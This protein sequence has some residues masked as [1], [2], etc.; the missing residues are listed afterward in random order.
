MKK[1]ISNRKKVIESLLSLFFPDYQF[2]TLIK[3]K[4]YK[5]ESIIN[6][7]FICNL[8][9]SRAIMYRLDIQ[10]PWFFPCR[11]ILIRASI[12]FYSDY[13][14]NPLTKDRSNLSWSLVVLCISWWNTYTS[15]IS[16]S[17][18][19]SLKRKGVVCVHFFV[20][21]H[22]LQCFLLSYVR[23]VARSIKSFLLFSVRY[24]MKNI[25]DW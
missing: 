17:L 23:D 3:E 8:S 18:S 15:L 12:I 4:N 9:I 14:A 10:Q 5:C 16:L 21:Q 7:I 22:I 25:C 24:K 20:Y 1:E 13:S 19:L 2:Y 6:P 11:W